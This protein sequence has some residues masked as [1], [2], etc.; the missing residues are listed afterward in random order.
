MS[1]IGSTQSGI[2]VSLW[3]ENDVDFDVAV[4]KVFKEIQERINSAH[5]ALR[6]IAQC[7]D[8]ADTY[9]EAAEIHFNLVDFVDELGDLFKDLKSC[10]K[11]ALGKCPSELKIEF[12]AYSDKRKQQRSEAKLR[13]KQEREGKMNK[14]NLKPVEEKKED[15]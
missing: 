15:N 9:I 5:C 10:S 14:E 6:E 2:S 13:E 7:K 3:G 11:Q 12:K 4:D 1:S 8:R